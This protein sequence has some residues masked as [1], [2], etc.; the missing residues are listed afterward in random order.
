[1]AHHPLLDYQSLL[2]EFLDEHL[3]IVKETESESELDG[4]KLWF[5]GAS[6]LLENGIRVVLA[7][8]EGQCF[9]FSAILG[10]DCTNN[11][12]EYEACAMGIM[13][14]LEYQVKQL[15]VFEDLALVIYQ[16]R[17]EW[18]TCD[19][20]LILYH[21]HLMEISEHFDKITFH[22]VPTGRKLDG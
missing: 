5:D 18:E 10:F 16:L 14:A 12:A 9:P 19:P 7:S 21:S 1:M 20:K 11:M 17:G 6:N 22:Y 8:P 4:W 3:M 15:K 13:I 2:H